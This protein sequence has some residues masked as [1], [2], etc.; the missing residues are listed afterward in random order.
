[1]LTCSTLHIPVT[2]SHSIPKAPGGWDGQW[3]VPF[4][5]TA[6]HTYGGNLGIKGNLSLINRIP[7]DAPPL[8]PTPAGF[9]ARTQ[10]VGVGYVRQ[11]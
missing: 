10:A 11:H 7:F 5:W 1:M 4:I 8:A 9:D 3:G 2:S 6:L